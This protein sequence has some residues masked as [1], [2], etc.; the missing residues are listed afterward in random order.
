MNYTAARV[1]SAEGARIGIITCQQCGSAV[2]ID[3]AD[4]IDAVQQHDQWHAHIGTMA[5]MV[6]RLRQGD[7]TA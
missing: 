5:E 7:P 2:L 3:P 1:V 4:E 6:E